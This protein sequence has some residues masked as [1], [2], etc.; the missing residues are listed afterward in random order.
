MMPAGIVRGALSR[1]GLIG[2]VVPEVSNLP[3][4]M[5]PRPF[6]RPFAMNFFR[7]SNRY[8]PD[9]ATKTLMNRLSTPMCTYLDQPIPEY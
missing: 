7:P 1:L 3:Q 8:I 4:C 6:S 2:V 5:L 9:K